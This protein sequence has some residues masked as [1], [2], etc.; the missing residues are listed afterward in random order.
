MTP[1][2]RVRSRAHMESTIRRYSEGCNEAAREKMASCFTL[3][4]V[5][6]FPPG[7][8]GGAWRGAHVIADNWARFVAS[9]RR[10]RSTG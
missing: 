4:A 2:P 7:M 5:H 8:Y 6:Y 10:G 3:D 1:V 9:A